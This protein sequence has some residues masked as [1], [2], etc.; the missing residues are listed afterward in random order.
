MNSR[1]QTQENDNSFNAHLHQT[2]E[3]KKDTTKKKSVFQHQAE[4]GAWVQLCLLQ[5]LKKLEDHRALALSPTMNSL[6]FMS[7]L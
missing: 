1:M 4:A 3:G 6:G 7:K 5:L 2:P